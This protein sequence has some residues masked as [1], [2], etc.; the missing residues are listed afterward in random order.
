MNST[1]GDYYVGELAQI[2]PKYGMPKASYWPSI[3]IQLYIFK[4]E[5]DRKLNG[6]LDQDKYDSI[7]NYEVFRTEKLINDYCEN[8]LRQGKLLS[9]SEYENDDQ[10]SE[11]SFFTRANY[12]IVK[13]STSSYFIIL[14]NRNYYL[15]QYPNGKQ[16]AYAKPQ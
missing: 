10:H 4:E 3:V 9:Y 16:H 15:L 6:L 13:V 14:S 11:N 8:I 2:K 5:I 7:S 1:E 12:N